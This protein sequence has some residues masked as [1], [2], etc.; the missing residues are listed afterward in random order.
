VKTKDSQRVAAEAQVD[1]AKAD[2]AASKAQVKVSKADE[3]RLAAMFQYTH[4]CAPYD[5]VI[6]SRNVSTGDFVRAGSGNPSEGTSSGSS[7]PMLVLTRTDPM[8]FEIGVPELDAP[9]VS[10]GSKATLRLQALA[11]REFDLKVTRIAPTLDRQSRTLLAQ[12][13][14]PN[15][16]GELMPGMY[17][18]GSIELQRP[19]VHAIPSSAVVQVGNRMCCYLLAA[20]R[21]VRTEIQ[22]GVS[23]GA[24]V[25]V[26][27][28]ASYPTK[29]PVGAWQ[30]FDGTEQVIVGDLSEL[31]D[32]EK[33][34]VSDDD[35]LHGTKLT[36][37]SAVHR[38]TRKVALP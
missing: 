4:I 26:Q 19:Q 1:K 33:V 7:E 37:A 24:W 30:Q 25:E 21:A 10:V 18:Y 2:L 6:T 23:D 9:Y 14:L 31:S 29:G 36:S 32:E 13:D 16:N 17:A 15:P 20:D 34:A 3:Q 11:G 27:K 38:E 8:V 35:R 12:V 5:G 22:T 28:R